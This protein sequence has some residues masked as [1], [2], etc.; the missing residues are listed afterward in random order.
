MNAEHRP[1]DL[2]SPTHFNPT[3]SDLARKL[4]GLVTGD[5]S[6][7]DRRSLLAWLDQDQSRWRQCALVFLEAQVIRETFAQLAAADTALEIPVKRETRE[8]AVSIANVKPVPRRNWKLAWNVA[9]VASVFGCGG[10]MGYGLQPRQGPLHLTASAVPTIPGEHISRDPTPE[11]DTA[12]I[13]EQTLHTATNR[14]K[15]KS[16]MVLTAHP[17]DCQF[18]LPM[19]AKGLPEDHWA[20][21]TTVPQHVKNEWDRQGY[22]VSENRKYVPLQLADGR[23]VV[24]PI[25]HVTLKYMGP[26]AL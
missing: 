20:R 11:R 6:E 14:D 26:H 7:L 12:H 8:Q 23:Q 13:N 1:Q 4:D 25:N 21:Q 5:L 16:H 10:L 18:T 15:S 17:V 3:E 19:S 22:K 2:A 24:V 9:L